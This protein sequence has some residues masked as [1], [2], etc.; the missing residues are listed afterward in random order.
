MATVTG[1]RERLEADDLRGALAAVESAVESVLGVDVRELDVEAPS[2]QLSRLL[3]LR[4]RLRDAT[5]DPVGAEADLVEATRLAAED[6]G[7]ADLQVRALA[8]QAALC[9]AAG[10]VAA[11]RDRAREAIEVVA[12]TPS[13]A[14]ESEALAL[15]EAGRAALELGDLRETRAALEH[16]VELAEAAAPG[17][18]RDEALVAALQGRAQA[19]RIAG[20][21]QAS[22]VDLQRAL[23]VA[24]RAFG[25]WSLEVADVLNDLGMLGKFSGAFEA[26]AG[27][28]QRAMAIIER[29]GGRSHPDLGAV[30]HNLGGLAHARGEYEAA[31][32][33]ARRAVEVHERALGP[34]HPAT[35]AD[36]VALAAI[37][38]GRGELPE[39]EQ[40][41]ADALVD[42]ER[43]LGPEHHE[44][45]VAVNNLAAIAQA[46]GDLPAAEQWY[47]RAIAIKEARGESEST[48]MAITLNNLGTVLRAA[49]R[50]VEA[51]NL[52][53]H[54]LRILERTVA[55]GHPNLRA[56][57]LNLA[58]LEDH[59]RSSSPRE[60][61][62]G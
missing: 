29:I 7:A 12:R 55:E 4:G 8:G 9:R 1:L 22:D 15:V 35:I 31:E 2:R 13:V 50:A 6:P 10:R 24:E 28:L 61:A 19:H 33:W 14:A 40:L 44:V 23:E 34:D 30:L 57:R 36:R 46:R 32:P 62:P 45:A 26:S 20:N 21:L 60:A 17:V 18:G 48:S 25:A 49:G 16:A 53:G 5:G 47:R 54:A 51:R 3:Y 38:Q 27:H 41:L 11:A 52:Y 59:A 42:L 37:L 43:L 39:A 56:V 58:R